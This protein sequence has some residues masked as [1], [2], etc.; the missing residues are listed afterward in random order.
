MEYWL[1]SSLSWYWAWI[2]RK[3]IS[4][5]GSGVRELCAQFHLRRHLLDQPSPH[6][7]GHPP[8]QWNNPMGKPEFTFLA[9]TGS[10]H[11]ELDRQEPLIPR[12]GSLLWRSLIDVRHRLPHTRIYIDPLPRRRFPVTEIPCGKDE[13]E[14]IHCHLFQCHTTGFCMR[15][16]IY[17]SLFPDG[18]SVG[19]SK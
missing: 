18:L 17:F 19:S 3:G 12:T 6:H 15:M 10:P 16:D 9:V 1:S 14:T 2:R 13:G 4:S 5:A 7:A 11:N 8:H